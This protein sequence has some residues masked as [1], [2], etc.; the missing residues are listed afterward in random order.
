M[1]VLDTRIIVADVAAERLSVWN[2]DGEL[3]GEASSGEI[4]RINYVIGVNEEGLVVSKVLL[5]QDD[6]QQTVSAVT[7]DGEE[8]ER[9]AI[10]PIDRNLGEQTVWPRP[11]AVVGQGGRVYASTAETYRVHAFRPDGALEYVIDVDWPRQPVS[12]SARR[13][14]ERTRRAGRALG[15][16][17]RD[18]EE[19]TEIPDLLPA[20]ENL[21]VDGRGRLYVFPLTESHEEG[22]PV[23]VYSPEGERIAATWLPFQSWEAQSRDDIY[24]IETV[25]ET[26]ATIVVRYRLD[27]TLD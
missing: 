5:T 7:E 23:D 11:R 13:T 15:A 17:V 10:L 18:R 26:G 1:A 20:L 21:E 19:L 8:V 27:L 3:V 4:S 22:Y 6:E 16:N 24:R 12:E 25:P 14:V 2:P 9:Y